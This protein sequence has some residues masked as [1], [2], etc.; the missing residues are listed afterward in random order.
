VRTPAHPTLRTQIPHK[1]RSCHLRPYHLSSRCRSRPSTLATYPCTN[2]PT[3]LH[4]PPLHHVY[5][6]HLMSLLECMPPLYA[7]A[8]YTHVRS[9]AGR[10]EARD[11]HGVRGYRVRLLCILIT[12]Y[13]AH[14]LQQYTTY[15]YVTWE[16]HSPFPIPIPI[17][18]PIPLP[19]K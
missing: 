16:S 17:P 3:A 2:L 14:Q 18:I 8:T 7:R 15:Y 4:P 10:A 11:G 19:A 5:V 9:R 1:Q 6:T 13:S 12:N